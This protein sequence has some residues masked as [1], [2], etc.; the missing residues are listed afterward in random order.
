MPVAVELPGSERLD[1]FVHARPDPSEAPER[2][3]TVGPGDLLVAWTD[4]VTDA[5]DASRTRFGEGRFRPALA[6]EAAG[7]ADAA[8]AG[9]LGAID[10][11]VAG[12]PAADDITLLAIGRLPS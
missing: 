11:F 5:A 7:G 8:V 3:I 10:A 1:P 12:Q 6:G 2:E 9:V 4:G